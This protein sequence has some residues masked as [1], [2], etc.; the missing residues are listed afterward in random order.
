ME[1]KMK[2]N[3]TNLQLKKAIINHAYKNNQITK[4]QH[5]EMLSL[6]DKELEKIRLEN[7]LK[8]DNNQELLRKYNELL[9]TY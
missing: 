8:Q 2:M 3:S 7:K 1:R 6:V 9:F 5:K 4:E